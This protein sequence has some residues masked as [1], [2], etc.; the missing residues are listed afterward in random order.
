MKH[1]AG[2]KKAFT[3]VELLIVVILIGV[4]A[5]VTMLS[6]SSVEDKLKA[7]EILENL[8]IAKEA[9]LN[10]YTKNG[11]WPAYDKKTVDSLF[12]DFMEKKL[13]DKYTVVEAGKNGVLSKGIF[14]RYD[15]SKETDE[16]KNNLAKMAEENNL[17]N[18]SNYGTGSAYSSRYYLGAGKTGET[19]IH[20]PVEIIY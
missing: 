6:M 12:S 2:K 1:G 19:S 8:R 13:G 11:K 20:L 9:A 5:G 10:Y 7:N 17:W 16:V 15:L 3:L 14:I 18:S 4:L